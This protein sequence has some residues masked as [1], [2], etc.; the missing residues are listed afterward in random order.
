MRCHSLAGIN[1]Q[2]CNIRE[3]QGTSWESHS[4]RAQTHGFRRHG[5]S[6]RCIISLSLSLSLCLHIYTFRDRPHNPASQDAYHIFAG[7][8]A[9]GHNYLFQ[10]HVNHR[11]LH[12]LHPRPRVAVSAMPE[13]MANMP[14]TGSVLRITSIPPAQITVQVWL[15]LAVLLPTLWQRFVGPAPPSTSQSACT[16]YIARRNRPRGPRQAALVG[17]RFSQ[18]S[19]M[20][21]RRDYIA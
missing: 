16:L 6:I 18:M 2:Q 11:A 19:R 20:S 1:I 7:I 12:I 5:T 8:H 21:W 9:R 14:C 3:P 4:Y 13:S 15:E 17:Q 10:I